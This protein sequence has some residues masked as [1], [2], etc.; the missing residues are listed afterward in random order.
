VVNNYN[1][2]AVDAPSFQDLARRNSTAIA[3]AVADHLGNSE[4]KLSGAVRYLASA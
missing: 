3:D 2:N 4:S 1:I